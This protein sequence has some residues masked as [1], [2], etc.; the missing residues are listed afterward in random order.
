[1]LDENAVDPSTDALARRALLTA[2]MLA[3]SGAGIGILGITQGAVAGSEAVLVVCSFVF[4]FGS[5]VTLLVVPSVSAQTIATAATGAFSLNLCVGIVIAICGRGEHFNVFVYLL[6]FFPLLVF[7]KLVNQPAV[8]QLLAKIL[9][10]APLVLI[11]CLLPIWWVVL[12]RD[13]Q[14]LLG[15]FCLSYCCYAST[16]H[17][18]TRYREKY[19]VERERVGSLQVEAGI[20]ESISDCF[21]SLD[22]VAR[23]I[24][25]NDAACAEL[26]VERRTILNQTLSDAVPGFLSDTVLTELRAASTRPFASFFEVLSEG[27]GH[28]YDV[29]CFPRSDGLSIYFRNITDSMLSRLKLNEAHDNLRKQAELLDKAQDA[30]HVTDLDKRIVYWNKG[31]ERLYGWTSQEVI[32]RSAADLFRYRPADVEA[33]WNAIR[34]E[35]EWMGEISQ[36]R[37]D[38]SELIV[39]S[40]LTLVAAEDGTPQSI[41]AINTDITA[42]KADQ[43]RIEYLAFYDVITGLPNRQLLR[44]RLAEVLAKPADQHNVGVLLYIDLDDFK[45]LNDTMGHDVGDALLQQVA[46]RLTD[47]VSP[48]DIVAR[49]GGDEFVVMLAQTYEDVSTAAVAG[50]IAG[51][52]IL[53]AFRLPFALGSYESESKASIGVTL[54][55]AASDSVDQLLKRADLAMYRAKARGRNGLCFFEPSMQTEIDNRAALR[56]DLG[57]ALQNG[58]F[59]L[60]YQPQIDSNALVIGTEALLRWFHPV[61]GRVPPDQFIPLAEEAGLIVELGRWVLETACLQ[62]AAWSRSPSMESLTVAVNVSVRQLLDPQFVNLVREIL[63]T[64]G[65]NPRR[66]KLE[67]TESSTMEK[68]TEVIAIMADL[69]TDGVSFSL[70]DFGTGYSS[71]SHLQYLPLDQLKID[72]SFVNNVLTHPKDASIA[73]TIIMLGSNLGLSVIAEGVET[74]AQRAFLEAEGCHLYQGFLYSPAVTAQQFEA[75]VGAS[76]ANIFH[77]SHEMQDIGSS[78]GL[79]VEAAQSLPE[80]QFFGRS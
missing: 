3:L 64:S 6:W 20:L 23:L 71:L 50:K 80:G 29:R 18:V 19:L 16:V 27:S 60:H 62:I 65:A 33:R 55:S 68:I 9:L 52:K 28:W 35:G 56:L 32:G 2:L 69:K 40:R 67:V 38:G 12:K 22:L 49:P 34:R 30:I 37:R 31:A 51:D 41:L 15:V 75:F 44:D 36:F 5:L 53:E 57:R 42:R 8:G 25:M 43:A 59:Q 1:M 13:E 10:F 74:E 47:S 78:A 61:R 72:R 39:E 24:Y 63:R 11:T 76:S 7:N 21:I 58:E 4:S 45:T 17:L 46:R 48:L 66:L 54:F 73:R 79:V 77:K 14:F 70:D 26:A